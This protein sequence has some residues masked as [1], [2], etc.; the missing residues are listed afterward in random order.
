MNTLG[1][2][3]ANYSLSPVFVWPVNKELFLHFLMIEKNKN[4]VEN[5][6]EFKFQ[7]S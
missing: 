5:C 6:M 1:Q 2:G 7:C 3:S 4:T